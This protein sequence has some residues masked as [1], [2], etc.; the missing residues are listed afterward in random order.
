MNP[1]K[2]ARQIAAKVKTVCDERDQLRAENKRL[3]E[4]Y[5]VSIER[6]ESL[7]AASGLPVSPSIHLEGLVGGIK[8]ITEEAHAALKPEPSEGGG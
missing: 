5:G 4:A 1:V 7:L 6:L 8:E 3:R 2:E